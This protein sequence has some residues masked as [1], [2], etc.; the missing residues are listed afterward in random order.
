MKRQS[1]LSSWLSGAKKPREASPDSND[2]GTESRVTDSYSI[3]SEETDELG[4][5]ESAST[6]TESTRK[7]FDG[8]E[9]E[10]QGWCEVFRKK[11]GEQKQKRKFVRC[12]I[13]INYPSVVSMHCYRQRIPAIATVDGTR[14]R[15]EVVVEHEKHECHDAAV[16]AERRD[17]MWRVEPTTFVCWSKKYGRGCVPENLFIRTCLI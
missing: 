16:R 3:M 10:R 13:C 15:E 11:D 6:S 2:E 4:L 8:V 14:Y 5:C 1:L 12:K 17:D 7:S 9:P